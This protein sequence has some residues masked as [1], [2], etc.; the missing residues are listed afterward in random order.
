MRPL[1]LPAVVFALQAP[2]FGAPPAQSVLTPHRVAE[3][4]S[5][6]SAVLA[7]DGARAVSRPVA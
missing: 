4:R 5:V 3:L 7:P 1:L 6:S 2:S